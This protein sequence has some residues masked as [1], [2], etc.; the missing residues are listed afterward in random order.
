MRILLLTSFDLFPPVHGG[1]SIAYNFIR[2]AATRHQVG[3]LL[4]HLYSLGGPVDLVGDNV[5]VRY[6]RPSV[7]DRLRV[8][9]FWINPHYCR[10]AERLYQELQP[11]VVQCETLWPVLAGWYLHRRHGVPLVCVEYNVEGDKFAALQRPW[12]L[13]AAVRVVEGFACRHADC[14]VTLADTDRQRLLQQYSAA[15][16]RIQTIRPSPDLADLMFD[17]EQRASVRSRYGLSPDQPLLTFVGNLKYEPNQ[18]AVRHIA[19][20]LYSAVLEEHPE[21]WFA[22]IGQGAEALADCQRERITF[23]GYLSR[24]DLV[25]HLSATDVFLVPV[26]TGSG[27]RVKIPEATACARAVVAT[28]KAA[29]GLELF[30][31]DEIVRV[32]GV[33]PQFTAAVLRLIEDPALR[34]AMGTRARARTVREFGWEKTLAQYEQMYARIGAEAG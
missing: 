29:V 15:P 30:A 17:A 23:T 25:A 3:A 24:P 13:V 32:D 8:L 7:F 12:P 33:G 19:T 34:Q 16:E 20:H 21:A 31:D 11:D 22:V 27:I 2:H 6:C 14:V 9:S 26:Q 28:H 18:E 10:A 4:S 5:H 1:S